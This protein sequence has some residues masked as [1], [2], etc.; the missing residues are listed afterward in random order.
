MKFY[1]VSPIENE[2][3]IIENGLYPNSTSRPTCKAGA[4]DTL[5]DT[6]ITGVYGFISL[7]DAK[8]FAID[9]L[10]MESNV[11]VAFDVPEGCEVLDDQEYDGKAVFVV[12]D[13]P[14]AANKV[15]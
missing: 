4:G 5:Q 9:N 7:Y 6:D 10:G 3:S 1:H 11:I 14:I 2:E 15:A 8:G 12:T 13:E